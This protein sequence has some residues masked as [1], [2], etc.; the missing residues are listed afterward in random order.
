[1]S[2]ILLRTAREADFLAYGCDSVEGIDL[3]SGV[4]TSRDSKGGATPPVTTTHGVVQKAA[5]RVITSD[6]FELS[7]KNVKVV[8]IS[9]KDKNIHSLLLV[10]AV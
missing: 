10:R 2:C 4:A 5:E 6:A 3:I 7:W 1:M 9:C 8:V